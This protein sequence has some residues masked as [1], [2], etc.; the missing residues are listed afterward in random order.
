MLDISEILLR[1]IS[2][3]KEMRATFPERE[4]R[5]VEVVYLLS[6]GRF[7]FRF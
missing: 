7:D 1:D 4:K 3:L 6:G 5:L 2:D